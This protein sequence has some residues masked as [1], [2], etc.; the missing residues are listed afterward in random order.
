MY[1]CDLI[2]PRI[3]CTFHWLE[4]SL[5]FLFVFS[6]IK[7]SILFRS[8]F[9]LPFFFWCCQMHWTESV[10]A[11]HLAHQKTNLIILSMAMATDLNLPMRSETI[12]SWTLLNYAWTLLLCC[13][14]CCWSVILRKLQ[15]CDPFLRCH[16]ILSLFL[17]L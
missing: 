4:N 9:Y 5:E 11:F 10:H 2:F 6:L 12:L 16:C 8:Q 7:V 1:K 17:I 14:K 13:V 3:E 15:M